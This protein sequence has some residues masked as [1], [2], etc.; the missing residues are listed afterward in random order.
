MPS[1][2]VKTDSLSSLQWV[3]SSFLEPDA[4]LSDPV[5]YHDAWG[6]VCSAK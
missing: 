6:A 3:D 5:Q 2:A 1:F 4:E